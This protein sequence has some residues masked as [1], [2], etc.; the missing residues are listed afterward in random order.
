MGGA[1]WM[2]T[3]PPTALN[4]FALHLQPVPLFPA[5]AVILLVGYLFGVFWLRRRGDRWPISRIVWWVAGVATLL[6]MT[7]T[8]IDGYGMELFSVHMLQHMVINMLIP[9]LLV[10]G[11]PI[12]LLLRALPAR[13]G[14]GRS[15]RAMILRVLHSAPARLVTH[16]VVALLL[17]LVSLYAL[18]LPPAFDYLMGTMWGHNLMLAH[19]LAI[20]CLYFWGVVGVDPS[21]R[22]SG[23]GLHQL[24]KPALRV[25]ELAATVPFHAFF[26]V[27]VMMSTVLIVRSYAGTMPGWNITPLGD[28]QVGGGIAWGFTELPTLVVLGVLFWQWQKADSRQSRVADRKAAR[29]GDAELNDYN[30]QLAALAARDQTGTRPVGR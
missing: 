30:A 6:L 13:H 5:F 26:G 17:F 1:M 4:L 10:L 19:F 23:R 2:P 25:I 29:N 15:A 8:G 3:A 21:P 20:G 14:S 24:S 9:I 7:A 11:A 22:N 16:P 18:Y 12:T 28:Q 27:V